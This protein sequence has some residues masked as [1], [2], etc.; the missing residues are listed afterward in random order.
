MRIGCLLVTTAACLLSGVSLA[1][2]QS[3]KHPQ[4]PIVTQ[5][6]NGVRLYIAEDHTAPVVAITTCFT[7]GDGDDPKHAPGLAQL[8]GKLFVSAGTRHLPGTSRNMLPRAFGLYPWAPDGGVGSDTTTSTVVVPE[9]ALEL[10]LWLESDRAGYF[11]DG[12]SPK[13]LPGALKR[14][15][16]GFPDPSRQWFRLLIRAA[17]S[18]FAGDEHGYGRMT[19]MSALGTLRAPAL[20]KWVRTRYVG[21][22]LI[23]SIVGD[24]ERTRTLRLVQKYF[25]DL[26]SGH[27]RVRKPV[28]NRPTPVRL[29]LPVKQHGLI[30]AWKTPRFMAPGDVELDVVARLLR[31]T[32]HRRLVEQSKVATFATAQQSS[33][34]DDSVFTI[35]IASNGQAEETV[36]RVA[37]EELSLLGN[38]RIDR[39]LLTEAKLRM[40]LESAKS[41]DGFADRA[42]WATTYWVNA[43]DPNYHRR[44][45]RSYADVTAKGIASAVSKH[46]SSPPFVA[47]SQPLAPN[48]SYKPDKPKTPEATASWPPKPKRYLSSAEFRYRPPRVP[49]PRAFA[50]PS[51]IEHKLAN[52][53]RVLVAKNVGSEHVRIA[54]GLR[55]RETPPLWH[56]PAL[57]ANLTGTAKLNDGRTFA[58]AMAALPAH[59]G[60]GASADASE[61]QIDV[62]PQHVGKALRTAV[63]VL[64]TAAYSSES[65]EKLRENIAK[66]LDQSTPRQRLLGM[67]EEFLYPAAHRYRRHYATQKKRLRGLGLSDLQAYRHRSIANGGLYVTVVGNVSGQSI[68]TALNEATQG[69]P[70]R[71]R[72]RRTPTTL[73]KGAFLVQ[74]ESLKQVELALIL[75]LPPSGDTDHAA[76]LALRMFFGS[77]NTYSPHLG[78]QFAKLKI[79]DNESS[80][81][82]V[83]GRADQDE[84]QFRFFVT[85]DPD[86]VTRYVEA[87]IAQIELLRAQPVR[88]MSAAEAR[89]ELVSW[90]SRRYASPADRQAHMGTLI[91]EGLPV[92]AD[93]SLLRRVKR[94]TPA[95]LQSAAKRNFR[96]EKLRV[97]AYG[98]VTQAK[99]ALEK[100]GFSPVRVLATPMQMGTR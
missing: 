9:N 46:L 44:Y 14:V 10:A 85:V 33:R 38:G 42:R 93:M 71:A 53:A 29:R 30:L 27:R 86:E 68:K 40:L 74:D 82:N 50:P 56:A 5:L 79:S 87:T 80:Y 23:V 35:R 92:D 41:R 66:S 57:I 63:E 78:Q 91:E 12:I 67:V 54:I 55:W 26:P 22:N 89:R 100:L 64:A 1:R 62:L 25:G 43:G 58:D 18:G 37:R 3:A 83:I 75:P 49:R 77:D 2:A 28:A 95:A 65:F 72:R 8:I 17:I 61:L 19:N 88:S 97:V 36:K 45:R 39:K 20:R 7:I 99:P 24:V 6:P 73:K 52:G 69:H 48:E 16:D 15:Q 51:P 47:H 21:R 60:V 4:A 98:P 96:K 34:L 81:T 94:L 31:K 59:W 13:M 84:A 76:N 90:I 11:S 32:L 70:A